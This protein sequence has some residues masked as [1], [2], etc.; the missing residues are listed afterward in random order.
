MIT[1]GMNLTDIQTGIIV[2][3]D[4]KERLFVQKFGRSL[5]AEDPVTFIFYF[6]DTQDEVY[7]KTALE[8]VDAKY[9][10]HI[11]INHLS[12]ITL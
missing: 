12:T 8:N 3:L 10:Q 2:Q 11:D 6:K 9:I 5:R 1:E 7:L 4:G